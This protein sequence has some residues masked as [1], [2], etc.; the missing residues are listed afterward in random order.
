MAGNQTLLS[1]VQNIL[2]AMSSDEVN[3]IS[4]TT[5]SMQVAQIIQ[6]KYYDIAA[7]G[8][9]PEHDDLFQLI[10]SNDNTKPTL[11]YLPTGVSK[12]EWLKYFDTN[13]TSGQQVSQ[14]GSYS[15]D[16][17]TDIVNS[18][19]WVTT[20]TT[21]NTIGTGPKTFTVASSSLPI[22][23]GQSALAM[24]GSNTMFGT[25]TSYVGTTL[26]INVVTTTGSGTFANWVINNSSTNS[27]PGYK[28]INVIGLEQF[29]DMINRFNNTDNDVLSYTFSEGGYNFTLYY[30]NDHQPQYCT[31]LSNYYV[32]FDSFDNTQDTTLQAAKTLAYGEIV[33]QFQLLD[34]YV[35][36]ID[37]QQFPLLLNEAKALAFYELKQMPHAK[38]EQEI[39]RQWVSVQKDK[40][41]SNKPGYFDQL[42]NLGRVPRT[43]GYGNGHPIYSWMRNR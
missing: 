7:R 20:S 23:S 39:K 16:L 4:D 28:Y 36:Q 2:S 38:A 40:S 37:D 11:M 19:A 34:T 31:V 1:M 25:V 9:L 10:P 33:P 42:P 29:M 5:E 12:L 41:K 21:S 32:L 15:H 18:I 3:S 22:V 17:N 14:Y 30:K 43:G 8:D 35:P 26:V 13:V 24:S 6:N 27:L